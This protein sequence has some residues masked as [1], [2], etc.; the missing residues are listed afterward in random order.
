[1]I[2]EFS[3]KEI[4]AAINIVHQILDIEEFSLNIDEY[5]VIDETGNEIRTELMFSLIDHHGEYSEV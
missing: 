1:M 5:G 2:E 3:D 4:I